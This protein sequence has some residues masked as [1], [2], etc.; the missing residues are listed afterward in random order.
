LTPAQALAGLNQNA[1]RWCA[2]F[3]NLPLDVPFALQRADPEY[4]TTSFKEYP[5]Y[6]K[7]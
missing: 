4:S 3:F 6:G 7:S 5:N 1:E 2:K